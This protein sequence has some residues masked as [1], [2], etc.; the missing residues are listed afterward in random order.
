[1]EEKYEDIE[2]LDTTPRRHRLSVRNSLSRDSLFSQSWTTGNKRNTISLGV[3]EWNA[4]SMERERQKMIQES[5]EK[6]QQDLEEKVNE[7]EDVLRHTEGTLEDKI[8]LHKLLFE[9]EKEALEE[10]L[11]K[12]T[13]ARSELEGKN[14]KLQNLLEQRG[15]SESRSNL[16]Q[17]INNLQKELSDARQKVEYYVQELEKARQEHS[18]SKQQNEEREKAIEEYRQKKRKTVEDLQQELM[19]AET[20]L[21]HARRYHKQDQASWEVKE[22][23]FIEDLKTEKE[24]YIIST[25][26][27]ASYVEMLRSKIAIEHEACQKLEKM[28]EE[29][30]HQHKGEIRL[31][32][33]EMEQQKMR[34]QREIG[35]AMDLVQT[36][37]DSLLESLQER[38]DEGMMTLDYRLN[39]LSNSVTSAKEHFDQKSDHL[40]AQR[41]DHSSNNTIQF[42]ETK[43]KLEKQAKEMQEEMEAKIA[44]EQEAY[45]KLDQQIQELKLQHESEIQRLTSELEQHSL[46]AQQAENAFQELAIQI[47]KQQEEK[48]ASAIDK[49]KLQHESEI[50]RL[51]VELEQQQ[52]QARQAENAF[53]ELASQIQTKYDEKIAI[54][55]ESR[56]RLEQI[57]DEQKLQHQGELQ[58]LTIEL[59]QQKHRE[60]NMNSECKEMMEQIASQQDSSMESVKEQVEEGM[61]TLDYRLQKFMSTVA[62]A[63]EQL[64][65][66]KDSIAKRQGNESALQLEELKEKMEQ[67]T[68]EYERDIETLQDQINE[69]ERTIAELYD[70]LDANQTQETETDNI[71]GSTQT[72]LTVPQLDLIIQER[73]KFEM[74]A[75]DANDMLGELHLLKDQVKVLSKKHND[76]VVE[77]NSTIDSLLSKS[78]AKDK[79]IRKLYNKLQAAQ[80]LND[81]L[82]EHNE[83]LMASGNDIHG[84]T[85]QLKMITSKLIEENEKLK[86]KQQEDKEI[87]KRLK[88]ENSKLRDRLEVRKIPDA[89][90]TDVRKKKSLV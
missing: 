46:Q 63:K 12:A 29:M 38:V 62:A 34:L 43:E 50:Q 18:D 67:Q 3:A 81:K 74:E 85:E 47:Q 16:D 61:A 27:K 7:L 23:Q 71:D 30:K 89:T 86:R 75:I 1:M 80:N 5:K 88:L 25:Q 72:E 39:S 36:Q 35:E 45:Q 65:Q 70:R 84:N 14:L 79:E 11:A 53:Q 54:E 24:S 28:I 21:F 8:R 77:L 4:L 26:E 33:L 52:L 87:F 15:I 58:L 90:S 73:Y 68:E 40:N 64:E 19:K 17:E 55:L 44:R 32:V 9:T 42:E 69:S 60:Q 78:A 56:K 41:D 49:Q 22:K 10:R 83:K 20:L 13:Q 31:L 76:Q 6:Y 59:E 48:T 66:E 37:Q 51:T 2:A 82:E 57:I